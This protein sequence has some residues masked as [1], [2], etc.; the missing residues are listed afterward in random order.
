MN[1]EQSHYTTKT[2]CMMSFGMT[3]PQGYKKLFHAQLNEHEISSAHK[4]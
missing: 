1:N 4:N 2:G 3:R